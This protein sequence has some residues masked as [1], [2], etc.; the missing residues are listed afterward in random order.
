M[1][2]YP[3]KSNPVCGN[4]ATDK[5]TTAIEQELQQLETMVHEMSDAL[6]GLEERI[7]PIIRRGDPLPCP[8]EKESEISPPLANRLRVINRNFCERIEN[9]R[10]LVR[11]IEL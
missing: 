11:L 8:P 2:L 10:G 7:A 6:A 1:P 4:A 5:P 9:L 3:A